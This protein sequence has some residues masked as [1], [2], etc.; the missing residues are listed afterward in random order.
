M[1]SKSGKL[2]TFRGTFTA[3]A[4][5]NYSAERIMLEDGDN[6]TAFRLYEVYV[7]STDSVSS[8]DGCMIVSTMEGGVTDYSVGQQNA[9]DN[10]QIGWASWSNTGSAG[11][12]TIT[13]ALVDPDNII[14][15]DLWLGAFN[16]S[17]GSDAV[18]YLIIAEK[19]KINLNENLYTS[20]RNRSQ[21]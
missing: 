2:V 14:N 1:V 5:G 7:W 18:N 3:T 15:E 20:V 13:Q 16:S 10:R 11:D 21:A 9:A 4:S 6:T 8:A 19:I 17:S 12:R